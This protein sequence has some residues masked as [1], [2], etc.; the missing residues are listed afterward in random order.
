MAASLTFMSKGHRVYPNFQISWGIHLT[1]GQVTQQKLC[2]HVRQLSGLAN[3]STSRLSSPARLSHWLMTVQCVTNIFTFWPW[4]ANP[5]AKVHQKGGRPAT[6]PGLSSWQI[7]SPASTHA[8]DICY[9][10]I[11]NKETN[12]QRM[13]QT[14][15]KRYIG[16]WT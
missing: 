3:I 7:S 5:W 1:C 12:K 9:K 13:L 8:R 16:M 4:G 11:A 6:H 10:C 15:G 14:N 2:K